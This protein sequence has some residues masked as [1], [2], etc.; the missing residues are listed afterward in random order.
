M[1]QKLLFTSVLVMFLMIFN[2]SVQ[3]NERIY[4]G[5]EG[6]DPNKENLYNGPDFGDLIQRSN[7]A[8]NNY[9]NTK[10]GD[11]RFSDSESNSQTRNYS[12]S[13]T[14]NNVQS[15]KE[16]DAK[17]REGMKK[18]AEIMSSGNR[19][20]LEREKRRNEEERRREANKNY[21]YGYSYGS[22]TSS[23]NS[24]AE[25]DR[26]KGKWINRSFDQGYEPYSRD[27]RTFGDGRKIRSDVDYGNNYG[28]SDYYNNY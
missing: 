20:S 2:T 18:F 25:Y 12:S 21:G 19:E 27:E 16:K 4:A 6:Y 1:R 8:N 3:A 14:R 24:G 22:N 15:N 13:N 10:D 11:Y 28:N 7:D 26:E 17:F 5:D 23:Y 9:S